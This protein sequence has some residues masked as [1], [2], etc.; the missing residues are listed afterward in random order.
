MEDCDLHVPS[1]VSA[2][3]RWLP[4]VDSPFQPQPQTGG[5]TSAGAVT[6]QLGCPPSASFPQP[7]RVTVDLSV[8]PLASPGRPRPFSRACRMRLVRME[9][10]LANAYNPGAGDLRARCQEQRNQKRSLAL[11]RACGLSVPTV[12]V[13]AV[14][15]TVSL[16]SHERQEVCLSEA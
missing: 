7:P 4:G 12:A 16:M 13:L 3:A 8:W 11:P 14:R 9:G 10:N 1:C 15:G 2:P 5:G 6:G